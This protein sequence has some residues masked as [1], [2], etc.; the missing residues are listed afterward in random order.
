MST[1]TLAI[2]EDLR[3]KLLRTAEGNLETA[4]VLLA[5][6]VAVGDGGLR[7]L[8]TGIHWC[9]RQ[10][11]AERHETGLVITS[12]GYV[13]ALAEAE[14]SGSVALWL[15]THPGEGASPR[16]SRHDKTVDAQL[17][18]LFRLRTGSGYYG[19]IVLS[20]AGGQLRFT[21]HLETETGAAAIGRLMVGRRSLPARLSRRLPS[22]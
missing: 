3:A 22:R 1:V 12:D 18:D 21:G 9:P 2:T 6:P 7:L 17:A 14:A 8:A 15:H 19:S 5:S 11:Y 13:P 4:G 16:P 10:S 20:A